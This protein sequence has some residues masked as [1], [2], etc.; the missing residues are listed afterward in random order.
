LADAG[1]YT[2]DITNTVATELTLHSRPI[3]VGLP[4]I[5]LQDSLALVDLYN[6]TNGANWTNNTNWL[7][8]EPVSNW[9]GVTV[10]DA[11]V[12]V[13]ELSNN[14]LAGT[15]P[16]TIGNLTGL[17][18]LRLNDNHLSGDIPV[19]ITNLTN[20]TEYLD[21]ARNTQLTGPIPAGIGALTGLQHLTLQD[22][23]L[24]GE[25]PG[26]IGSLINLVELRLES[27]NLTGAIPPEIGNLTALTNLNL[28]VNQLDGSIPAEIGN[29]T[30]LT[31]LSLISNQLTGAIPNEIGNL[32]NLTLLSLRFNRLSGALPAEIGNL[33]ELTILYLSGNQF[34]GAVP[35]T[36][37]NLVKLEDLQLQDNLL[38][39]LPDLSSITVLDT[40]Q[41]QNNRFTFEDIE[42]NIGVPNFIYTPQENI[43]A[44][45]NITLG[46]G[47]SFTLSVSVG[48]AN[49]QYQW[50]KDGA[51]ISGATSS[52]YTL[53][54]AAA[55]DAGAYHC[56]I[57]NSVATALTLLSRPVTIAVE[58]AL[59]VSQTTPNAG[60]DVNITV[61]LNVDFQPTTSQLFYRRAGES[62]YQVTTLSQAG[63]QFSGTIPASFITF[64]GAEYYVSLS[65]NQNVFTFPEA[66]PQFSP[67]VL[68]VRFG[69]LDYPSALQPEIYKMISVPVELNASA[70]DSVLLDNYGQYDVLPRQWRIFRWENDDYAEHLDIAAQFRPG[71][72]FWLITR[73][74]KPFNLGRGQSV[75]S[76][77]AVTVTLQPGWN[78]I[79]NP[80]AFQ[81]GWS[82][83]DAGGNVQA[84]VFYDG[85]QYLFDRAV[86]EPWEGYFVLN[87]G[88]APVDLSI[89]PIAA[90][91]AAAK[92]SSRLNF[93]GKEFVLKVA[94]VVP[95]TNLIDSENYLGLRE[96]AA[97]GSDALD[98][99]EPPAIGEFVRLIISED[100]RE[101]A[102]N[103]KPLN[104]QGQ[105]WEVQITSSRR[106]QEV[107]IQL[108][109]MTRLPER[110]RIYV[111][112]RDRREVI[113]ANENRFPVKI[114]KAFPMRRLKIIVG[115]PEFA[116]QNAD[117]IAL[118]PIAYALYQNYP[119]PFNPESVIKYQISKPGRVKL[120]IFNLMGQ[121]IRTLVDEESNPGLHSAQWNGVDETGRAVAS[122]VYFYRLTA[123][124]F[125]ATR[126][127]ILNR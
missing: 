59:S 92:I 123:G 122:G 32:T 120:E 42:P 21:L 111:L 11:R 88:G 44:A 97:A 117:N 84:P 3:T 30:N 12:T 103:F 126:K 93:S 45:Q 114:D 62:G 17:A 98:F 6:S 10:A 9:F 100:G 101:F 22:N 38:V 107:Q 90:S 113:V 85:T 67:Q 68:Q 69:Q 51:A 7:S 28:S 50:F 47:A 127:L 124:E 109:E 27:N 125:T 31:I 55:T 24:T 34:T 94:A 2:C 26:E 86:L 81:L 39:D 118:V 48:G 72:A 13:L 16:A 121:K 108:H 78:Q 104:E 95:G 23:Q 52:S 80:F 64:R 99:Y 70:I 33:T 5:V 61:T 102:G 4:T 76:A 14:N 65:D 71:Q 40:L 36:M 91:S 74:G 46:A 77:E 25:I 41:I 15:L 63:N 37:A 116:E 1:A 35:A 20:L 89:P 43:G 56:A 87:Q 115:T 106:E 75:H 73:E 112:D 49:N 83:V 53:T 19:E 29:L 8:S 60:G 18:N 58:S 54:Q 105:H 82:N 110:F 79:A 119:N 96:N 57:T 66:N